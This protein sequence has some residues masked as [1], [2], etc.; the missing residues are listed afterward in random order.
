MYYIQYSLTDCAS[1]RCQFN[2]HAYTRASYCGVNHGQISVQRAAV[3]A[4]YCQC[5]CCRI[6][7][8]MSLCPATL[9]WQIE[10]PSSHCMI[11]RTLAQFNMMTVCIFCNIKLYSIF[12]S[13]A[14]TVPLWGH[15]LFLVHVILILV[16]FVAGLVVTSYINSQV[17]YQT[18]SRAMF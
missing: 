12:E 3:F 18:L 15:V 10:S 14:C 11:H 8:G 1:F 2:T 9:V 5:Y 6:I 17:Y 7:I 4:I 16:S 13:D